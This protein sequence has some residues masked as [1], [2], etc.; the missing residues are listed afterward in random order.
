M[1]IIFEKPSIQI[2][3]EKI[4][5]LLGKKSNSQGKSDK[6]NNLKILEQN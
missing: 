1:G 4:T 6:K 3:K 2:M 5:H